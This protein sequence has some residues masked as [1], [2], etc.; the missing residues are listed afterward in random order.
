MYTGI[1]KARFRSPV[2]PGDV[3]ETEVRVLR[4]KGAFRFCEGV[5]RAGGKI[6]LTA[7]FS[8]AIVGA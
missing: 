5:V 3:I 6:C 2:R 7:E 4:E 8:F 1:D